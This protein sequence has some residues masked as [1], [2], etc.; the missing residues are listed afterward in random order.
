M[1]TKIPFLEVSDAIV[2][3]GAKR[4][5]GACECGALHRILSVEASVRRSL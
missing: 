2:M 4:F 1:E 3:S 5:T